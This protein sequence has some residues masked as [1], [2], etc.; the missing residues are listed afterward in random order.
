MPVGDCIGGAGFHAIPAEDAA[1]IIDVVNAGVPFA[2][3]NPVSLCVFSGLYVDSICR[4]GGR[5]KKAAHTFFQPIF[6]TMQDVNSTVARLK[7]H[8]FMRVILPEYVAE[9]HAKPFDQ[10]AKRFAHFTNHRCHI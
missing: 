6:V 8:R 1:R 2:R 7:V 5:T 3:G 4:A 9:G 10:R